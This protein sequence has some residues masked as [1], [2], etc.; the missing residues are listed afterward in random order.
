[1]SETSEPLSSG[2]IVYALEDDAPGSGMARSWLTLSLADAAN[3][4][5]SEDRARAQL[6]LR[7]GAIFTGRLERDPHWETAHL[8]QDGGGWTTVLVSEIAA[9]SVYW[10]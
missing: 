8:K 10:R 3:N 7:S 5:I 6:T 1:M 9:V 4:C 2:G